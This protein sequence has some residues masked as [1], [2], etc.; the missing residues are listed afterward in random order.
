MQIVHMYYCKMVYVCLKIKIINV[1]GYSTIKI[2][3]LSDKVYLQHVQVC[4]NQNAVG[5][6]C[7]LSHKPNQEAREMQYNCHFVWLA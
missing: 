4:I 5:R 3:A 7:K 1:L 6:V 2:I